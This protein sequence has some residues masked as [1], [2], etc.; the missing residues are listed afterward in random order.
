MRGEGVHDQGGE[1]LKDFLGWT[2]KGRLLGE[3]GC[4]R[5]AG[6]I[7]SAASEISAVM[8]RRPS[9]SVVLEGDACE[10]RDKYGREVRKDGRVYFA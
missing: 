4:G 9:A 1:R 2:E 10:G 8:V 3:D 5:S 7:T 6:Y